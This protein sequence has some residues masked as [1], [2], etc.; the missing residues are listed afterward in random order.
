MGR[1]G[2]PRSLFHCMRKARHVWRFCVDVKLAYSW[3]AVPTDLYGDHR[4]ALYY[5]DRHKEKDG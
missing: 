2:V 5:T 3:N 4:R 1:P